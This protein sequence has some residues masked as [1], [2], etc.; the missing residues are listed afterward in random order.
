MT[1]A[2]PDYGTTA[3]WSDAS[4]A[5]WVSAKFKTEAP[6]YFNVNHLLTYY[7][8][9]DYWASVD[10]RAKNILWRTWD[11]LIWYAT[12]YDGD[13]A[14]SIRN[15]AF[16]VYLYNVTR[17]T[18][19]YERRKYA[20]EGHD[21]WLWCLVLANF[22][23]ELKSCAA[24]LRNQLTT[25]VML[26][27][28]NTVMQGNWSE[29]QYNKSGKLKYI[30]TIETMNYVYTLTGNRELHR[31]QF[32]TDRAR[33]LDAR[34]GA[35]VYEGDVITFTVV[36]N[37]SATPSHLTLKSGDLYYFG[38]KL[39]GLWLQGPSRAA[40]GESLTLDFTGTLATNDPLMLGGASCISE[41]D[42]TQMGSQ[43][44][45]TVGLSLCTMLSKLIMPATN[46]VANAPL[47][48]GDT[49]KLEYV[50]ITGQTAVHTGT[51]GVFDLSKHTR[52]TTLL[53]GGT[54]LTNI[55][56]PE[57]SPL[58][59]LVMP[60]TLQT[61]TLRY[62]P[63]LTH[64]GLTLQGTSNI[65]ELNFAE[66]PNLSW[67]T[68]LTTCP[69]IDH[70]R[71][72]GM[73]GRVRSAMLRPFMS[74]YYGLTATGAEQTYPALIGKV[75]LVDVV[76]DFA[77]MQGFFALCGLELVEAQYS[78]YIFHD[79]SSD[80]AN[81]TNTD[82]QTGYAYR[83]NDSGEDITHPNGYQ[84]SGHVALLHDM[85]MP[86]RGLYY[87]DPETGEMVMRCDPLD[88]TDFRKLAN[89][90]ASD[91]NCANEQ[92]DAGY[93]FFLHIPKY[94]YK[95]INYYRRATK[96]L[97][98]ST[99]ESPL[100]SCTTRLAL[101]LADIQAFDPSTPL[102]P[103]SPLAPFAPLTPSHSPGK[104][105]MAAT[106]TEGGT[107][108][109]QDSATQDT[110]RIPVKGMALVRFPATLSP[111]IGSAFTTAD[112]KVVQANTLKEVTAAEGDSDGRSP[113][114]SSDA[115]PIDFP[116]E[117][118]HL[119]D[120]Y[121]ILNVPPTADYLH[122][123]V[124]ASYPTTLRAIATDSAEI[125]SLEPQWN[126]H[127]PELVGMYQ[128]TLYGGHIRS[129]VGT[130]KNVLLGKN[131]GSNYTFESA[132]WVYDTDG[133]PIQPIPTPTYNTALDL[134]NLCLARGTHFHAITYE[135]AKDLANILMAWFGT[136]AIED[137]IGSG[138]NP[139]YTPGGRIGESEYTRYADS[140]SKAG[141]GGVN[142]AWG[143]EAIVGSA[144]EWVEGISS[145]NRSFESL[146]K[147]HRT[148]TGL[149]AN[150]TIHV[151]TRDETHWHHATE[152]DAR[153][154]VDYLYQKPMR[155]LRTRHGRHCDIFAS[156]A[157]R[158]DTTLYTEN[159]GAS[160]D[161][162]Q[163]LP[164][165]T[166]GGGNAH[167]SAGLTFLSHRYAENQVGGIGV[168]AGTATTRLCYTGPYTI[169]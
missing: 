24:R 135:T 87:Q 109:T 134:L 167:P 44:N 46:G 148:T 55:K 99:I 169:D 18:W 67:Q 93:D 97:F 17:D 136:R 165:A 98:L 2:A 100:P 33:L 8:F 7:L 88:K 49:A 94:H 164:L 163:N 4:K 53:A 23:D 69:N 82:N 106:L 60:S 30:D 86:V 19:D 112:G 48:L 11:G 153:V 84:A 115:S 146:F 124:P 36:R 89:G 32:L 14:M 51:T 117:T 70:V 125:E 160:Q 37:A 130:G 141:S 133:Y 13:T 38:Y 119:D 71:I 68:L 156:K 144:P 104:A 65:K 77:T 140:L 64:S 54:S 142:A 78:E 40:A 28:F 21:S 34:Y 15:D 1:T 126:T 150:G 152:R 118:E 63:R 47:T 162:I 128:A 122:F 116:T 72:E 35:G 20:F 129:T 66:C 157:R 10:Q 123:T 139:V 56:L 9:T 26:N 113:Q 5:K 6:Q 75:Q 132:E 145:E 61:L 101:T 45:G 127:L 73:S 143:I 52:L 91:I 108:A 57:G 158:E 12:F 147:M 62:L 110:Y 114:N 79:L 102:S 27:E 159:Y 105:I 92:A 80:P 138:A 121:D 111:S 151:A 59:T 95:G 131:Q 25:Q 149:T 161:Y 120:A 16:M 42:L 3:G 168:H 76:D 29:R 22:E 81:V 83:E 155:V 85:A 39:N 50:D 58:Q 166:R 96:H 107:F 43:L 154:V 90:Q 137:I 103:S 41:L 31:T 74:G